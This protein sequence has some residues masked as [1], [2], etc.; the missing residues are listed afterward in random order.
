MSYA[1]LIFDCSNIRQVGGVEGD[2]VG[3]GKKIKG[4]EVLQGL[5]V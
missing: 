2:G 5:L 1:E 3:V 4:V